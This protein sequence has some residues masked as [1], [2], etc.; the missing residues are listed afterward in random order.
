MPCYCGSD[1]PSRAM[2]R[3]RGAA[4]A[5][6]LGLVTAAGARAQAP[7]P[8]ATP[9]P[10]TADDRLEQLER[11]VEAMRSQ[12]QALQQQQQQQ[13]ATEAQPAAAPTPAPGAPGATPDVSELA[14]R[15]DVLA[16]EVAAMKLG[17]SAATVTADEPQQGF[18]PAASK[19][20]RQEHGLSLGGYGEILYQDFDGRRDDG[21]P[22]DESDELTLERAVV[23]VGYKFNDQWLFNSELEWEEG[24]EE[25]SVEFA[26]LDYLWRPHLNVRF[27]HVLMPMGFLNELHEPTVYLG[28]KRPLTERFIIPSTWHQSGAGLFGEAGQL[29]WRTYVVTGLDASGFSAE[30]L[31][32]GR[33]EGE[34]NA[35]DF[36]WV[37][38]LD[39]TPMQGLLV[40]GSAYSGNS[41]QGLVDPDGRRVDARTSLF[42]GHGEWR[43]RG[44]EARA[45]FARAHVGDAARID[46]ALDLQGDAS[47]GDEMQGWYTQV[48]WDVLSQR[49]DGHMQL[50]P[51]ARWETIDTQ[52]SVP[53]GFLRN[54]ANDRDVL[55]LGL[56]FKP[57][58]QTV[59]KLD[60][61][62][63][64]NAADSGLD[65]WNLGIGYVF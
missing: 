25:N 18:G 59:I 2:R 11:E 65:Q 57:F 41:G 32:E 50:I 33:Q 21:S 48:G 8:T 36:A 23:Y 39:W 51:F 64:K 53:G 22:A 40:G 26:Y 31:R 1:D 19:V 28:A 61:Q 17:E 47:V 60:W 14:R 38:R 54:P 27:G 37:G 34:V 4:V 24:G 10:A 15:V 55:T 20:Y 3:L 56:S 45:L 42:E 9:A 12:L 44:L 46:A 6:F 52:R 7:A 49:G 62:D 63:E 16:E 5:L 43:W 58:E 13:Q 35:T 30:G 29:T